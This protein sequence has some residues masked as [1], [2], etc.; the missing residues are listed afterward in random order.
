MVLPFQRP[1]SKYCSILCLLKNEFWHPI[2]H[3]G[4]GMTEEKINHEDIGRGQWWAM[5]VLLEQECG[6]EGSDCLSVTSNPAFSWLNPLCGSISVLFHFVPSLSIS[7]SAPHPP[8]CLHQGSYAA[9]ADLSLIVELLIFLSTHLKSAR[10]TSFIHAWP[11]LY[12]LSDIS[13]D[14]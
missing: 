9:Q 2:F 14:Y 7:P 3:I 11:T 1:A 13:T 8:S 5:R 12:Q 6:T 10:M 4:N